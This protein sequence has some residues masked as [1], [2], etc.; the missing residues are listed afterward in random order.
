MA[1]TLSVQ[2]IQ[3]LATAADPTTVTIPSGHNL[4]APG[5]VVQSVMHE[6]TDTTTTSTSQSYVDMT[7]SSVTITTKQANS[8]IYLHAICPCYATSTC[9]GFYIGFKRGSTLIAGVN[10][11]SGDTWMYLNGSSIATISLVAE[12]QYLDSPAVA[13]GTSLTYKIGLSRWTTGTITVN[14]SGYGIKSTFLVQEVAT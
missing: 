8:K 1:G 11:G 12:R 13:A 10:G 4:I 14:Y 2:Q 5:H 6:F 3:G 7:G 9:N